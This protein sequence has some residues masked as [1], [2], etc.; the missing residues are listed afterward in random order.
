MSKETATTLVNQFMANPALPSVWPRVDKLDFA[1][2]L[3]ARID[4]PNRINQSATPLCGPAALVRSIATS[5]PDGY[6]QAGIDL[7]TR[8]TA[9]IGNLN[10]TAGNELKQAPAPGSTNPAD[11][12]MLGSVRDTSNWFL[13]PAGWFR[14]NFAGPTLPSTIEGWFRQAGYTRVINDTSL[15]GGDIPSVKSMCAKRASDLFNAGYYVALLIDGN[16]LE[17]SN[18]D[19]YISMYPDHWVVLNSTI[20]NAGT[21]DYSRLCSFK[22]YTWGVGDRQV[23]ETPPGRPLTFEKFLYKFYGFVAAKL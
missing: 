10:I 2:G 18:Q 14:N 22:I 1:S 11:W 16:M 9:R 23:P 3:L 6:A 4:D 13:S 19:D 20:E 7:Y 17:A 8:G 21:M 15:L 5:N 12:V